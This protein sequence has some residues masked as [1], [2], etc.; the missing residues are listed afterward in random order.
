LADYGNE[1]SSDRFDK[2]KPRLV[3]IWRH[4]AGHQVRSARVPENLA[5]IRKAKMFAA[6]E[7]RRG[8]GTSGNILPCP[9]P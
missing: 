6:V 2:L 8:K 7:E 9:V 4:E 3:W 5:T 1:K